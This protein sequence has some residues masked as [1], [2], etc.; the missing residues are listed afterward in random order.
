[1]GVGRFENVFEIADGLVIMDGEGKF[2]FLH[3]IKESFSYFKE[4]KKRIKNSKRKI[5]NYDSKFKIAFLQFPIK[6]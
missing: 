2:D 5:K 4:S 6:F 3:R 1:M